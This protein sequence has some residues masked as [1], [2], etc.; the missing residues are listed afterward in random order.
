MDESEPPHTSVSEDAN[1]VADQSAA[2]QKLVLLYTENAKVAATFWEWRH[3]VMERFFAGVAAIIIGSAW[4]YQREEL[5]RLLFI[6][7]LVGAALCVVSYLMDRVNKKILLGC[8]ATGKRIEQQLRS[9][10][11]YTRINDQYRDVNYSVF[12]RGLYL[13]TAALL[14]VM[15][16]LAAILVR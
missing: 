7:L 2:L 15:S 5:R 16:L 1:A 6:P 13:G 9:E 4:L 8:Y 14:L 3:K 12:L 10:G 11:A